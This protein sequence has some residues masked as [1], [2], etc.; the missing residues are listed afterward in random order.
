MTTGTKN[1]SFGYQALKSQTGSSNTAVGAEAIRAAGAGS[2]NTAIGAGAGY[3]IAGGFNNILCGMSAGNNITTG[4]HNVVIG[5]ADVPSA[6]GDHQLSISS[7]SNSAPVTWITGNS[8][9]VVNI[10]G[11]LTVAGSALGNS[12]IDGTNP[13]S[14][15]GFFANATP[16]WGNNQW[17]TATWSDT[18]TIFFPFI[19]QA[20]GQVQ[21]TGIRTTSAAS[22]TMV[23]IGIYSDNNGAPNT[24][25][26]SEGQLDIANSGTHTVNVSGNDMDLTKGTQYWLGIV[27]IGS[28]T[29]TTYMQNAQG[30]S[31]GNAL[32]SLGGEASPS[33]SP[34]TAYRNSSATS[35]LPSSA[36][37][38]LYWP[39]YLPRVW[40]KV[41]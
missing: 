11:S 15:T 14:S 30:N 2:N 25:I 12:Y 27:R 23:Q 24:M 19:A 36:G 33:Q 17:G 34:R 16:G 4:S 13:P 8:S 28:A 38:S 3:N 1:T 21:S 6:T 22:L 20:T 35:E 32:A 5:Y 9:G 18:G 39:S 26:G 7:G 37:G 41:G 40:L 29:P 10:P 31:W